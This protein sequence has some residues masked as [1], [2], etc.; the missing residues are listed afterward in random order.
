MYPLRANYIANKGVVIALKV[1]VNRNLRLSVRILSVLF[2]FISRLD[3]N[4]S[5]MHNIS[6]PCCLLF[7]LLFHKFNQY[8]M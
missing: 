2:Y 4:A 7:F 3:F 6:K 8:K 1:E 5:S